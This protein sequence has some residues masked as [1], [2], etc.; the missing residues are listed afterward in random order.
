M[1]VT[2]AGPFTRLHVVVSSPGGTGLP[3]SVADPVR[4]VL[5]GDVRFWSTPALTRG[6]VLPPDGPVN[7][8]TTS[9][10]DSVATY[11]R[12][13]ATVGGLNFEKLPSVSLVAF[14]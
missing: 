1:N 11:T 14:C 8:Y 10:F 9:L 12:P 4:V 7:P 2:D 13:F 5:P 6:A 3:S